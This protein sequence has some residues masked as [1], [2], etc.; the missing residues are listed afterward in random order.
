MDE[1][2]NILGCYLS[3]PSLVYNPDIIESEKEEKE[4]SIIGE[5]FDSYIWGDNGIANILK[6]LNYNDYGKD[7]KLILFQFYLKPIPDLL[8]ALKE[9]ERYRPK[10]RAIG[11]P[12]IITDD[13]FFNKTDK[14]RREALKQ[15]ILAKM[16]L[17]EKVVKR[18][19]LD[20]NMKSL[21]ADLEKVLEQW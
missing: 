13:N 18:N 20:T 8:E 3:G 6:R 7:M 2:K 17:I 15:M 4:A 12:I 1:N 21:K 5:L 9:I 19:K 14:E 16:P 11:V 10:E